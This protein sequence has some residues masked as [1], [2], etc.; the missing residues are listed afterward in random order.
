M[1]GP[2]SNQDTFELWRCGWS[3]WS[4]RVPE[5]RAQARSYFA[6]L[7]MTG[8]ATIGATGP[9]GTRE[10]RDVANR[11]SIGMYPFGQAKG[12][13]RHHSPAAGSLSAAVG[14]LCSL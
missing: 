7:G 12:N 6:T 2:R 10:G 9:Q 14:R 1:A 5:D 11:V 3:R 8:P 13:R 4:A